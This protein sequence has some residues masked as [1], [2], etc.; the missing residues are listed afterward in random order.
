[1]TSVW[2]VKT[3]KHAFSNS[4]IALSVGSVIVL[5]LPTHAAGVMTL[6]L[7]SYSKS[8]SDS[9]TPGWSYSVGW[10]ACV[11]CVMCTLYFVSVAIYRIRNPPT[12]GSSRRP[13][14]YTP[15]AQFESVESDDDEDL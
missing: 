13:K 14:S 1:M 9:S 2:S 12:S 5:F 4:L 7:G 3:T 15:L 8:F 6:G 10:V 11:L